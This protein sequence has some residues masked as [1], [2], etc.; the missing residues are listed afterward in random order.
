MITQRELEELLTQDTLI[1]EKLP[2]GAAE[3]IYPLVPDMIDII[4]SQMNAG[5]RRIGICKDDAGQ[6]YIHADFYSF[7]EW[8]QGTQQRDTRHR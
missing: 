4:A 3:V 7:P 6:R 2:Q 8:P 1:P 5:R